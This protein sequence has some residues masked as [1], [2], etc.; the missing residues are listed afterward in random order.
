MNRIELSVIVPVY[1]MAG[2]LDRCVE[3]IVGQGSDELEIILVDDGSTDG[4]S[5]K[6]DEWARRDR[7]IKVI[8]TPNGGLS[9][10]RNVGLDLAGGT[11]ITFVDADDYLGVDTYRP[12]LGILRQH[13]EYDILEYAFRHERRDNA[14]NPSPLSKERVYT[15]TTAYWLDTKAYT[16][17]YAW[18]KLYRREM[19]RD[20][21]FPAG[22]AFEDALT[23][24][25]L[26]AKANVVAV[27]SHGLYHYVCNP[28]G[29][30]ATAG[31]AEYDTLLDAHLSVIN[32]LPHTE[33]TQPYYLY[34]L[35]LQ[36]AACALTRKSPRLATR[37]IIRPLAV[38]PLRMKLKALLLNIFGIKRLC[39]LYMLFAR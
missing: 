29:I 22:K 37:K 36:L 13:P 11:Y 24:P 35:N 14:N 1:N 27:T 2:T 26:L 39:R 15:D 19:F 7:R 9:R 3:S 34:V 38:K 6:T 20:V 16:H 28:G 10:A 31:A 25:L 8:H 18:N 30:T 4:S 5:A 33:K 21:R 12:L 32:H 17:A 23:L